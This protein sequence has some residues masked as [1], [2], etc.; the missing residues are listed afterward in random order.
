MNK[1]KIIAGSQAD[2]HKFNSLKEKT[3]IPQFV[4]DK[5]LL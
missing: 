2:I 4:K 1:L 3:L 5:I